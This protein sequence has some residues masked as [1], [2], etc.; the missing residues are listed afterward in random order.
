MTSGKS[1]FVGFDYPGDR[2]VYGVVERAMPRAFRTAIKGRAKAFR[3]KYSDEGWTRWRWQC[4]TIADAWLQ[5]LRSIG[6]LDPVKVGAEGVDYDHEG[7]P[8]S[9]PERMC[10]GYRKADGYVHCHYWLLVGPGQHIFD[11]TAH[12]PQFDS[13]GPIE[14]DRYVIDGRPMPLWRL[15]GAPQ[16]QT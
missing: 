5:E 3:S 8:E 14:L 6:G 16:D 11:P 2:T 1:A 10:S 15:Q 13:E 9:V 12:Q 4:H 7:G